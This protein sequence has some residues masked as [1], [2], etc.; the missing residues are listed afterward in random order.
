MSLIFGGKL[1]NKLGLGIN[2]ATEDKQDEIITAINNSGAP[3][4]TD[5]EGGG[6]ISVGTTAVEATFAGTTTS[7]IISAAT[8]N[9]GTL[10][11]GESNVTNTGGNAIAFLE[12]GE[13]ITI[14]YD[15]N[16]NA[17]Y[18]VASEASQNFWKGAL[19]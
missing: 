18:V 14:D 4:P 7:I 11:I 10:Y 1:F 15:D 8:D 13:S 9:A 16:S 2:P 5:I 6:K 12:A 3:T 17:V 19:L